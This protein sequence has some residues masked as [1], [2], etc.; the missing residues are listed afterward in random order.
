[1][2]RRTMVVVLLALVSLSGCGLLD[3]DEKK[4]EIE[5]LIEENAQF[6]VFLRDDNPAERKAAVE[7][8]LRTLPDVTTVTFEGHDVAYAKMKKVFAEQNQE[9]PE[10]FEPENLPETFVVKM[11]DQAAVRNVRDTPLQAELKA[12]PGV[13]DLVFT[14][15]TFEECKADSIRRRSPAPAAS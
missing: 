6:S 7:A 9:M 14:C 13:Q 10:N 2:F 12:L 3:R 5:R 4:E 15:T 8:R 11:K 1:M